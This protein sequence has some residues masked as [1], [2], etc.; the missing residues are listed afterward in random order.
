MRDGSAA[1]RDFILTLR[2][3]VR[4]KFQNA[5]PSDHIVAA[6]SQPIVLWKDRQF[7]ENRTTYAGNALTLLTMKLPEPGMMTLALGA[8]AL[9]TIRRHR[10]TPP[11]AVHR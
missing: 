5:V 11:S 6:G 2:P 9:L 1:L 4:M 8:I 10:S 3:L 7:A